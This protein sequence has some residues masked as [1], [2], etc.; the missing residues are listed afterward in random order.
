R[1]AGSGVVLPDRGALR[2]HVDVAALDGHDAAALGPRRPPVRDDRV[3]LAF[4]GPPGV[5]AR[6]EAVEERVRA[7]RRVAADVREAGEVLEEVQLVVLMA[8]DAARG[9]VGRRGLEAERT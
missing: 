6:A 5:G 9:L 8:P 3:L 4:R 2:V 1:A 7:E